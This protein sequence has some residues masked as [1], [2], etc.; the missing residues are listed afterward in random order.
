MTKDIGEMSFDSSV[1][2]RILDSI[3]NFSV[4]NTHEAGKIMIKTKKVSESKI[5]FTIL[6][7][8]VKIPEK[9]HE[10]IFQKFS[11]IEIKDDGYR[12]SRGLGL[13]YCKMAVESH[14]GRMWLDT[15]NTKGNLFCIELPYVRDL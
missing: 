2:E 10:K 11:Q 8:G 6:D 4:N 15:N 14:K 13:I 1:M 7:D 3:I 12:I 9:F 5:L